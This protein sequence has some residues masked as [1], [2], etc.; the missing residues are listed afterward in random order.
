[1]DTS[2]CDLARQ[3]F[4]EQPYPQ[5]PGALTW[6]TVESICSPQ[7][8]WWQNYGSTTITLAGVWIVCTV[9]FV[10]LYKRSRKA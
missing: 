8:S 2:T 4:V 5:A 1:M 7:P 3:A 6:Q 9:A 10:I